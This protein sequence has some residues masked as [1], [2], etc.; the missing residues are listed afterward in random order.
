VKRYFGVREISG[1]QWLVPLIGAASLGALL[2]ACSPFNPVTVPQIVQMTR[3][4]VPPDA[5]I[6]KM[7][8]SNTVYRLHAH[9]VVQLSKDGV[10]EKVLDYMQQTYLNA[11]RNDQSLADWD[12]YALGQ[13]GFF[14]GGDPVGWTPGWQ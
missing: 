3:E 1:L 14:Y 13:D 9:Q 11:V 2:V 10:N 7:K 8:A 6:A 5:I 12:N 4:G